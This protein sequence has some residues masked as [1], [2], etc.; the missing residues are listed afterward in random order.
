MHPTDP[1][2]MA[3]IDAEGVT[4]IRDLRAPLDPIAEIRYSTSDPIEIGCISFNR[5]SPDEIIISINNSI[6][7]YKIDGTYLQSASASNDVILGIQ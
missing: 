3:S 7:M 2:L 5:Y 4:M 1:N 6:N